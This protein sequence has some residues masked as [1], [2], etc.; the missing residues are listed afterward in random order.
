MLP[1]LISDD[2]RVQTA[3]D[4]ARQLGVSEFTLL[5]MRQSD[6]SGGLPFVQ[7]S[8]GRI[9]YLRGDIRAYLV[10]RRV[11]TLPEAGNAGVARNGSHYPTDSPSRLEPEAAD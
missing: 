4:T 3:A 10:A 9:G 2:D 8:P 11:G 1:N 7:L 6:N 5:R